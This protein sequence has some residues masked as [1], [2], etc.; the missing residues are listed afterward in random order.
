[1]KLNILRLIFTASLLVFASTA[2]ALISCSVSSSGFTAA[3]VT[4]STA[5]NITQS[6]FTVSCVRGLLTDSTTQTYSVKVNNGLNPQGTANRAL[7]GATNLIRYDVY[8]DSGCAAQW[9]GG[10]SL[11]LGGG[12]MTLSGLTPTTVTTSYWGC[13]PAGQTGLA[14]GNY[15]DTVSMTLTSNNNALNTNNTFPVSIFAPA[16]CNITTSPGNVNFGNYN[17]LGAAVNASASFGATCTST[18]PYTM[19]LDAN[20]GVVSGLQYSLLLNNTNSGGTSTLNSSGTGAAQ[21]FFIN[22]SMPAGQAGTC[23]TGSCSGLDPRT[24]TVTY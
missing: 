24:L 20:N 4:G 9:K 22:G 12:T 7:F 15:S 3:Y 1:M 17:A 10:A 5:T 23:A 14:T 16:V 6:S 2:Q 13:I 21:T 8:L 18:L 11:P 19:S